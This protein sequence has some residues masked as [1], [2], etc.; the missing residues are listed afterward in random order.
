MSES[1]GPIDAPSGTRRRFLKLLAA[2]SVAAAAAGAIPAAVGATKS[3]AKPHAKSAERA[4]TLQ[5]EIQKQKGFVTQTLEAIRK[6]ELPPGSEPAAIFV[7][8]EAA[9]RATGNGKAK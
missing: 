7:P 6:A 9:P 3:P 8:L 1:S 2:G 4:P 5:A